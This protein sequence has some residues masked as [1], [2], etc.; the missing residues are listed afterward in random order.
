[1]DQQLCEILKTADWDR[2][3]PQLEYFSDHQIRRCHW[4]GAS[5]GVGTGGCALVDGKSASDFVNDAIEK[6]LAEDRCYN[7]KESLEFNLKG[8]VRS[9]EH[10]LVN[11]SHIGRGEGS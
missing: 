6:L 11:L 10:F 7:F 3:V 9:L 2:L 4:R 1:M 8:I 5:V